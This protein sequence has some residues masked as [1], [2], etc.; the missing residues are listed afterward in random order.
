MFENIVLGIIQG[1]TEWLPISSEGLTVL[2][3]AA[4]TENIL[5]LDE[6]IRLSL[7]LHGGTFLAALVYFRN[8]VRDIL[9]GL[10][11]WEKTE[12]VHHLIRF[13]FILRCSF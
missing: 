13:L 7:F 8:D 5:P 11:W 3:H 1:I 10:F 4:L 9:A 12:E 2:A 6:L